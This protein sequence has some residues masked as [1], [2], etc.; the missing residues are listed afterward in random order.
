MPRCVAQALIVL[1]SLAAMVRGCWPAHTSSR[2]RGEVARTT[3]NDLKCNVE[4][5]MGCIGYYIG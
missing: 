4:A 3:G 2:A 1:L 5:A